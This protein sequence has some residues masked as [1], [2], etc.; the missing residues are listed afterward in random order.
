MSR[1]RHCSPSTGGGRP[2]SRPIERTRFRRNRTTDDRETAVR[3][4]K[5]IVPPPVICAS[6]RQFDYFYSDSNPRTNSR[7][8]N[9]RTISIFF[10]KIRKYSTTR[11]KLCA[12][13]FPWRDKN[14]HVRLTRKKYF[15]P[16]IAQKIFELSGR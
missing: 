13:V 4:S 14:S 10:R 15:F 11:A 7:D 5:L 3:T 1:R 8:T 6:V 12:V 16:I 9:F 2:T